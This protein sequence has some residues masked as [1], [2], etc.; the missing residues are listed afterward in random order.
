M[1]I[2]EFFMH[3]DSLVEVREIGKPVTDAKFPIRNFIGQTYIQY[4]AHQC[5]QHLQ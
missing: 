5:G 4:P 3:I 2:Y 1:A